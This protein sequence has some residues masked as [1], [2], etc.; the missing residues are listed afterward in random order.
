MKNDNSGPKIDPCSNR[1]CVCTVIKALTSHSRHLHIMAHIFSLDNIL[2]RGNVK[3]KSQ[4]LQQVATGCSRLQQFF[5]NYSEILS[6]LLFYTFK[7]S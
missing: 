1:P 7:H 6:Q 5:F 2:F 3:I 4:Y